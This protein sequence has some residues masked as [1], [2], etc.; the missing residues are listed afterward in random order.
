MLPGIRSVVALVS[1]LERIC[2]L[3]INAGYKT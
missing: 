1:V 3:V 2:G